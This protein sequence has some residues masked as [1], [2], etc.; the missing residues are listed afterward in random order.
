LLFISQKCKRG[1]QARLTTFARS[2]K[3][4]EAT[5]ACGYL[6]FW[7]L[8]LLLLAAAAAA[9]ARLGLACCLLLAAACCLL[10]ADCTVHLHSKGKSATFAFGYS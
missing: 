5:F 10:L 1:E 3:A 6:C 8:L 9:A 2:S 7:L 4:R